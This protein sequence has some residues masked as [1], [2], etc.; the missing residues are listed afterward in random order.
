MVDR[1]RLTGVSNYGLFDR[2]WVGILDLAGVWWLIR[3]RRRVAAWCDGDRAMMLIALSHD[4]GDYL[5]DVFVARFDFWLAFGIVAQVLFTARFI[6][7][8]IASERAGRSVM[9]LAFW[10]FS[11]AGGLL[12]LVYGL[13]RREPVIIMGQALAV[14]IYVR[15]L[16]LIFARSARE[17]GVSRRSPLAPLD[18][19]GDSDLASLAQQPREAGIEIGLEVVDVLEADLEAQRR[20]ARVP[21]ASRCGRRRSRTG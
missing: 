7:Q 11:M 21:C 12:T 14:F 8:W 9:P 19:A 4:L 20:A 16:M 13:V 17:S 3:R 5:Y 10:I 2:L 6:V 18:R 15:N 1:P